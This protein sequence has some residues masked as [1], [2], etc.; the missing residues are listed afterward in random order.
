M[1]F[2]FCGL[3]MPLVLY[4]AQGGW[5][6]QQ[7]P[8]KEFNIETP[9]IPG[10]PYG[11]QTQDDSSLPPEVKEIDEKIRKDAEVMLKA[12]PGATQ[13]PEP[14]PQTGK[15]EGS[16]GPGAISE[17]GLSQSTDIKTV[18]TSRDASLPEAES[19]VP[20]SKFGDGERKEVQGDPGTAPKTGGSDVNPSIARIQDAGG[21][22]KD[23]AKGGGFQ[24]QEGSVGSNRDGGEGPVQASYEGQYTKG[25]SFLKRG[26]FVLA[27]GSLLFFIGRRYLFR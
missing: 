12:I 20:I 16:G 10:M 7:G 26:I 19:K 1:I 6:S 15:R 24:K 11:K 21:A 5:R 13:Q 8:A 23:T 4:G 9:P 17:S 3:V 18:P 25:P 22:L 14:K 27:L 2:V